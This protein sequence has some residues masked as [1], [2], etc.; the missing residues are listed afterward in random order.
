MGEIPLAQREIWFLLLKPNAQRKSIG[1]QAGPPEA[2]VHIGP[3]E[4]EPV[5]VECIGQKTV[6]R[7]I[8]VSIALKQGGSFALPDVLLGSVL[9]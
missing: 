4:P 1:T 3:Y 8:P 2:L 7:M 6:I 9:K 5:E